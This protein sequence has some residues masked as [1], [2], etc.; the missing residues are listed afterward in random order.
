MIAITLTLGRSPS[1][2]ITK[3][4]STLNQKFGFSFISENGYSPHVTLITGIHDDAFPIAKQICQTVANKYFKKIVLEIN[5]ISMMCHAK[6]LVYVRWKINN[7][8]LG[9]KQNLQTLL[10][11]MLFDDYQDGVYDNEEWI[12]KT[13]LIGFDTD[14][15]DSLIQA[16]EMIINAFDNDLNAPID[17]LT[18][19]RYGGQG[20]EFLE[21]CLFNISPLT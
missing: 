4:Q 18:L 19:I 15:S 16:L 2:K 1:N 9:L 20:E 11:D 17:G 12:A 7:E 10:R 6:P 13:S 8:L 5:C 21:K 3:I 14:Y